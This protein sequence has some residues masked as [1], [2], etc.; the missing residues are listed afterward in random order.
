M[1]L[2]DIAGYAGA[3]ILVLLGLAGTVF[4]A[5][6]GLPLMFGGFLL[7]AWLDDFQHLGPLTLLV[8]VVLTCVGLLIDAFAS[9]LGAKATGASRQALWGAFIGSLVGLFFGLPGVLLGPLLGAAVGE[10]AARQ[11]LRQ[12]G[13]VSI[14]TF[15]GFII[16]TVAKIGCAFAML[17]TVVLAWFL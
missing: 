14:G 9:L 5:L 17:A 6:P 11:D 1:P 13:R 10:F 2:P 4:P 8:L 12:A 3:A 15:I 16:G 7:A